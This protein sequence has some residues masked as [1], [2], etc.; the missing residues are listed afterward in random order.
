MT[1]IGLESLVREIEPEFRH[2]PA[3]VVFQA[4]DANGDY[5]SVDGAKIT[6]SPRVSIVLRDGVPDEAPDL[7]P[8]DGSFGW[9]VKVS[10]LSGRYSREWLKGV[11]DSTEVV[12]FGDLPNLDAATLQPTEDVVAAWDTVRAETFAARDAA[13]GSADAAGTS[14]G[15]AQASAGAAATSATAASAS[16]GS[17]ATAASTATTAATAAGTARDGA[18]TARS[19]AETARDQAQA[20]AASK[21]Q[22]DGIGSL[23]ASGKQP[24]AQVP[25][26]LSA[27]S[28][29]R[30]FVSVRTSDG[31]QL[32]AGTVVVITLDKTLAQ[33]T[34]TPVADI[35]DITF[36]TGA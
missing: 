18:V 19:G 5:V 32:P 31:Q 4:V 34:A 28:L 33:V 29:T 13:A 27:S 10:I 25:D 21:G 7:E 3:T 20:V 9:L 35:A 12:P 15:A 16:A 6:F 23:D 36:T 17:A 11:P 26:R 8:T 2:V 24:E 22:P 14:A 30:A 1:R